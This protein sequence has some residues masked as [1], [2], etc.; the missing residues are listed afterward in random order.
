MTNYKLD[1]DKWTKMILFVALGAR[2]IWRG[3]AKCKYDSRRG[4]NQWGNQRAS[5]INVDTFERNRWIR[6]EKIRN[7]ATLTWGTQTDW[8]RWSYSQS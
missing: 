7:H 5:Q 8:K 3:K 2:R 6:K 4:E 1:N